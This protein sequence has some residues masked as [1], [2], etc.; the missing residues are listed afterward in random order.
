LARLEELTGVP[1]RRLAGHHSNLGPQISFDRPELS[2]CLGSLPDPVD[3]RRTEALALIRAGADQ[4]EARPDAD[5][6]GFV[7][8]EVDQWREE[9]Y[10][11]RQQVETRNR[12]ALAST[13]RRTVPGRPKRWTSCSRHTSGR[14][15]AYSRKEST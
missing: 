14:R 10:R 4:L 5:M 6:P 7:A 2:P 11:A 1:L 12:E 15:C 9:K 13:A 3:P 8:C